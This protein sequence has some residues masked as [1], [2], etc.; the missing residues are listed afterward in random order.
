[1]RHPV[2][3]RSIDDLSS[4]SRD[5]AWNRRR[6]SFRLGS[7]GFRLHCIQ[8]SICL[9]FARFLSIAFLRLASRQSDLCFAL[10]LSN[11]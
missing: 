7:F 2:D 10:S 11:R 8:M 4:L 5:G 6:V 1:M 9:V 3:R